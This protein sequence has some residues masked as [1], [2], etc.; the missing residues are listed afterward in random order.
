MAPTAQAPAPKL[1]TTIV[2][3][4]D[5]QV[6]ILNDAA[7]DKEKATRALTR[8][9][10]APVVA[11]YCDY[12]KTIVPLDHRGYYLRWLFAFLSV[13]TR[14]QNNVEAFQSLARLPS[15]FRRQE[16]ADAV[17]ETNVGLWNNRVAGLWKFHNEFWSNPTLWYPQDGETLRACRTRL[18]GS[19]FGIRMAKVSFALEMAFPFNQEV[20]CLD[21]HILAMYGLTGA[22]GIPRPALYL[23]LEEHWCEVCRSLNAPPVIARHIIWDQVQGKNSTQYWSFVF[24]TKTAACLPREITSWARTA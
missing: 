14:W 8:S 9:L 11:R 6:A 15:F 7:S 21:T 13:R 2:Q 17:R 16:L 3:L 10:R 4:N 24:E 18:L 5:N 20:I 19:T 12:W 23:E 1:T 22:S